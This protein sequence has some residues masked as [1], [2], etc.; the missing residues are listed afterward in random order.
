[1]IQIY[2]YD[3]DQS[4][5]GGEFILNAIEELRKNLKSF[6]TRIKIDFQKL[7]DEYQTEVAV[8]I[9]KDWRFSEAS[10]EIAA[11]REEAG[12]VPGLLVFC[13]EDSVLAKRAREEEKNAGWGATC[14]N[15]AAA[16]RV[17][18]RLVV[19]HEVLHLL[20]VSDCYPDRCENPGCI[21]QHGPTE[22]NVAPWPD[23]LCEKVFKELRTPLLFR[24]IFSAKK[25]FAGIFFFILGVLDKIKS[26]I[27][28]SLKKL[29]L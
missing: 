8:A 20:R 25:V 19:W 9:A 7:S 29:C 15:L 13:N 22:E 28:K 18:N 11:M 17:N 3:E 4:G 5:F 24:Y 12:R 27:F 1:M 14:G 23:C 10:A 16:W 2:W 21:M 26:C 6:P